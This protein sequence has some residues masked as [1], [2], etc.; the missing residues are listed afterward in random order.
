MIDWE[1]VF[2]NQL[3]AVKRLKLRNSET[4]V[5]IQRWACI[6]TRKIFL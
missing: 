6:V 2:K 3:T 1:A 4:M 5:L